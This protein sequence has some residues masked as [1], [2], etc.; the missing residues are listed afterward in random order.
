MGDN[1][2]AD[3]GLKVRKLTGRGGAEVSGIKLGADLQ[4]AT[5]KALWNLIVEHKV[6]FL[7]DQ[8][9]LT[10]QEQEGFGKLL[11]APVAHPTVPVADGTSYIL[12]LDSERGG[13]ADS[14][15]TDVTFVDAYPQASVLRAV[16]VPEAG[17]DTIWSNTEAAYETLPE[18]LKQLAGSLRAV[19]T[20]LYDYGGRRPNVKAEDLERHANVF[21]STIY[22][23][24]HPVVRVH[25]ETGRPSLLLGH[26]LQRFSGISQRDSRLLFELLQSHATLEENTIRWN[27]RAGDVAIWDNRATQHKAINDYG[28][29][30]RVMHRVTIAGNA[31]VGLDGQKSRTL[32][33]RANPAATPRAA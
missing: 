12:E 7:R 29:Q 33:V 15:H 4:P 9:H 17:G 6:V 19:H 27:W 22:E 20:N 18:P 2:T 25:P 13:R 26:F 32:S 31:P 5:V 24:E 21:A 28:N 1:V 23:T 3:F 8:N 11:G 30:K 14:W 10:D 16:V